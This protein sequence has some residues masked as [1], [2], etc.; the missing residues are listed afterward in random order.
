VTRTEEDLYI[1]KDNFYG[2]A[3]STICGVT[4]NTL[5]VRRNLLMREPVW[6]PQDLVLMEDHDLWFRL[7]MAGRCA[8]LDRALSIYRI[9]GS[10]ISS[11]QAQLRDDQFEAHRRNLQRSAS[12]LTAGQRIRYR[13]KIA[14]MRCSHGYSLHRAGETRA[15]R[16]LYWQSMK[17]L[18]LPITVLALA[19][20]LLPARMAAWWRR[21]GTMTVLPP[22]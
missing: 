4:T 22:S 18:P 9:Y 11:R 10:S 17:I 2:F 1:G 5:M 7:M 15:A 21:R 13:A 19:K 16:G 12:R 14:R 6:F 20:A 3:A 8:F